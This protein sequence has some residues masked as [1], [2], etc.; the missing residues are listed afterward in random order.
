MDTI[1]KDQIN[2]KNAL[3]TNVKTNLSDIL[4]KLTKSRLSS[5]ATVYNIKG[6]SKMDKAQFITEL[7]VVISDQQHLM[8]AL[9]IAT[10]DEWDF[11]TTL[12]QQP[13]LQDNHIYPKSYSYLM[14]HGF[15]YLFLVEDKFY[16]VV[17]KEV[18]ETYHSIKHK[19]FKQKRDRYQL[20]YQYIL[21]LL[22]L[23]GAVKP[24]VLMEIFNSQNNDKLA[25]SEF[26]NIFIDFSREQQTFDMYDGYLVS[27]YFFGDERGYRNLILKT[28]NKPYYYIPEKSE[29]LKYAD[30]HYFEMT[31]QL[32]KLKQFF[33][34]E[35]LNDHQELVDEL[36][37]DIQLCCSM[38]APLSEVINEITSRG[39][40]FKN[41]DQ[42]T[43]LTGLLTDVYN[44]TRLWSNR[45]HK[46]AELFD[47]HEKPHLNK[48]KPEKI[49]RNEPCL[50]GSGKKYKK[51]CG[52]S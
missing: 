34:K 37:D 12:L 23:Y 21:G 43:K 29:I 46:P 52:G 51:C 15:I 7:K 42:V 22:S 50:C 20:V 45:G 39:I 33:I 3:K 2:I 40:E 31:P 24:E 4:Q 13:I 47:Q 30:G 8:H 38:E 5:L 19:A 16:F 9:L 41:M 48:I 49:G 14:T 18:K 36:I 1:Q 25:Q 35:L 17:P 28:K 44:H 27:D 6:R 10:S 26:M 32:V 11:F